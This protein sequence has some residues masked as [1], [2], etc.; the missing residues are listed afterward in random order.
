LISSAFAFVYVSFF[1][2]FG[3]PLLEAM[4]CD[5]PLITSNISSMPEVAGEAALLVN[6]HDVNEIA[7]A[8][9]QY[10]EN[11]DL[12]IEKIEKGKIQR[13]KFSWDESAKKMYDIIQKVSRS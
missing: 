4:H 8:L 3:L 7:N 9:L 12:R 10:F 1:E 11:E 2:G 13:T 6:P 5:V